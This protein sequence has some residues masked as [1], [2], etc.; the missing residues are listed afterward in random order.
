MRLKTAKSA[1]RASAAAV[2]VMAAT[3]VSVVNALN[4]ATC[5]PKA[6]RPSRMLTF[7]SKISLQP[8]RHQRQQLLKS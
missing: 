4:A 3:V 7:Q 5:Q 1:S 6:K 8:S 2:T